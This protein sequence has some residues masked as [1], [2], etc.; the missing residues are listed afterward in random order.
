MLRMKRHHKNYS[1]E[2]LCIVLSFK[3]GI[4]QPDKYDKNNLSAYNMHH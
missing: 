4:N 3:I 2:S 1:Y